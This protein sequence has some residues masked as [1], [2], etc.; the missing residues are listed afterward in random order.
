M[1][2][3]NRSFLVFVVAVALS[4]VSAGAQKATGKIKERTGGSIHAVLWRN[5]TDI[6]LR[7]L[8][9]G[10]GG[11]EHEPRG[12]FQFVEEDLEGTSPKFVVKDHDGVKWKVKLGQEAG[13]ET[14]ASRLVWAAGYF[15]TD[16]Y[17]ISNLKV[18]GLPA[19]LHRG[20]KLIG[21]DG[22]VPNVR[23]KRPMKD[24]KKVGTW[25]WRQS[26]FTGTRELNGLKVMM[27]LINNWDLKDENNAVYE[28]DHQRIY[29][30]SD[31]GASF[32]TAGRSWP[33]YKTKGN[34]EFYRRSP[35]FRDIEADT[36]DF[37]VPAR[38]SF[39]YLVN[40]KEYIRRIHLEWIGKDVP[41]DDAKWMG[42]LLARLSPAQLRDAFL[43]AG[44]SPEEAEGFA[45]VLQTRIAKLT[46]L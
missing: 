23:L 28:Q 45:S 44:Y 10:A 31:L 7:N 39:E 2:V 6:E 36:V 27:A 37:R 22:S 30:V 46:D 26:P 20:R 18:E 34:L 3:R 33:R 8:F 19:R 12:P 9:Y 14:A 5:P 17:F 29:L 32:G 42:M 35:F 25:Q 15:T 24:E 13:P 1:A 38:P 11:K 40:P 16:D 4:V 21:A 43:A 41:R